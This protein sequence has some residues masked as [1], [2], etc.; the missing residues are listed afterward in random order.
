[1]ATVKPLDKLKLLSIAF[2]NKPVSCP[3][4]ALDTDLNRK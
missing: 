3:P 1:M 2:V 4:A